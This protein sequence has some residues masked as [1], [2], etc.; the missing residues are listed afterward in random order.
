VTSDHYLQGLVY[1]CNTAQTSKVHELTIYAHNK[2]Q[3]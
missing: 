2:V 1:M 3:D